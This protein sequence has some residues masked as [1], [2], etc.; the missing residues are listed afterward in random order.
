MEAI[1]S[2]S[3]L[4][5]ISI[6][7]SIDRKYYRS[8]SLF[9]PTPAS[10]PHGAPIMQAKVH[11]QNQPKEDVKL[12]D[13]LQMLQSDHEDDPRHYY[14][15]KAE[16]FSEFIEQIY[17]MKPKNWKKRHHPYW[18]EEILKTDKQFGFYG[19]FISHRT[20]RVKFAHYGGFKILIPPFVVPYLVKRISWFSNRYLPWETPERQVIKMLRV[21]LGKKIRDELKDELGKDYYDKVPEWIIEARRTILIEILYELLEQYIDKRVQYFREHKMHTDKTSDEIVDRAKLILYILLEEYAQ[22][23]VT[24]LSFGSLMT[25][26]I[27]VRG[28]EARTPLEKKQDLTIT[29]KAIELLIDTGLIYV[30]DYTKNSYV[31]TVPKYTLIVMHPILLILI[32]I[33]LDWFGYAFRSD[34][35]NV[36]KRVFRKHDFMVILESLTYWCKFTIDDDYK[37]HPWHVLRYLGVSKQ[38]VEALLTYYEEKLPEPPE[39]PIKSNIEKYA[40]EVVERLGIK[41]PKIAKLVYVVSFARLSKSVNRLMDV[42]TFK[43]AYHRL[44]QLLGGLYNYFMAILQTIEARISNTLFVTAAQLAQVASSKTMARGT[45]GLTGSWQSK[46]DDLNYR[47]K[48]KRDDSNINMNDSSNWNR[49]NKD[50]ERLDNHPERRSDH[51]SG[52]SLWELIYRLMKR[53]RDG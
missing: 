48:Y 29:L 38:E 17:R 36:E 6:E 43:W 9:I 46:D 30:V 2:K 45:V 19:T 28:W 12:D 15:C 22:G 49:S 31:V 4:H 40:A 51:S 41:D 10:T 11:Q 42:M 39:Q 50:E 23:G 53:G 7:K 33:L 3:S 5:S 27:A 32:F 18:P 35:Y 25:E 20:T 8:L 37:L 34:A 44:K 1:Q 24:K 13:L 26:L 16:S 14:I 47:D 21:A 52:S